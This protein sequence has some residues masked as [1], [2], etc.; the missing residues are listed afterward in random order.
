MFTDCRSGCGADSVADELL[1]L[2]DASQRELSVILT[3]HPQTV[4][5]VLDTS[6]ETKQMAAFIYIFNKCSIL[7]FVYE[8]ML[9]LVEIM[10]QVYN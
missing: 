7:Y 9:I 6:L 8:Q 5:T 2:L 3:P 10:L 4:S 1:P